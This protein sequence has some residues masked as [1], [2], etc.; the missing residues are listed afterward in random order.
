MAVQA[1]FHLQR[2]LVVHQ[3]HAVHRTVTS[4]APNPFGDVNAV[5]EVNEVRQIVYTR[6]NQRLPRTIAFPYGFQ[7]GSVAPDLRVAVHAGLGGRNPGKTG[8]L[9]G[10]VTI[11]AIDSQTADVVLMT[12]R[13]R[14]RACNS[15]KGGVW[16]PLDLFTGP[17]Q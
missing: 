9:N 14:L 12:E 8:N 11:T 7:Q 17:K 3:W 5:V 13:D 16:G 10:S 4:I 15:S 1:P 2:R 6:P